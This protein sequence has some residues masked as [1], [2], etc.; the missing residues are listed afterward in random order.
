MKTIAF[1]AL[2]YRHL[3]EVWRDRDSAR[4]DEAGAF[5]PGDLQQLLSVYG[6]LLD[7]LYRTARQRYYDSFP[8]LDDNLPDG[9][10][11]LRGCQPWV[12]PYISQLL[13]VAPLSPLEGGRRAEVANAIGWRQRKGT[14]DVAE[15]IA[16]EVAALE[17]EIHEGWRRVA[18]TARPGLPLLPAAS[19]GEAELVIAGSAADARAW[20]APARARHPGLPNGTPDLRSHSRAV[21]SDG[22]DPTVQ[23]T[24]YPHVELSGLSPAAAAAE[25]ERVRKEGLL[26][27]QANRHGVPCF[28]GSYQDVSVRTVDLRTPDWRRGH[29][30]P[31]RI[32]LHLPPF[33]GLCPG[34]AT[35]KA[36]SA[37]AT[38]A[39]AS[40]PLPATLPLQLESADGVVTLRA[41]P[42]S[43][44]VW[45]RGPVVLAGAGNWRF[46]DLDFDTRP[47]APAG[48]VALQD[49]QVQ[50]EDGF[51]F[52]GS[53][54]QA[55]WPT[56]LAAPVHALAALP[57]GHPVALQVAGDTIT[58]RR[59][60]SEVPTRLT[61][62]VNLAL[63]RDWSFEDLWLDGE[64]KI[65][66][67]QVSLERCALKRVHSHIIDAAHPVVVARS[68]LFNELLAPRGR[69]ELEY[70]TVLDRC[71][72]E[73][74]WASDCIFMAFP[75]KDLPVADTDVPE[76]GC[77][78]YAR[79]PDLPGLPLW[80]ADGV[81]SDLRVALGSCT[82]AAPVFVS[83]TFGKPG[84]GV[85]HPASALALRHGAED[86]GELG[87]YH[88]EKHTLREQAV[89]DKLADYL[90]LGITPVLAP[91][92]TLLCAPP[93][94][95]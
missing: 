67:G 62:T 88:E 85:L 41:L 89:L 35:G 65:S 55:Q 56:D 31:K 27:R 66:A 17:A 78:R 6:E 60:D 18:V 50:D 12:L 43:R 5:L 91:D 79:L 23:R 10:G 7:A 59:R 80:M 90:P 75:R 94:A 47:L 33:E 2:Q 70:C 48:H 87:A 57:T 29:A 13:D 11:R 83:D 53:T 15:R 20:L 40:L 82:S 26:W 95:A 71:V 45:V 28:P 14:L 69:V 64:L 77:L 37:I 34:N 58:V 52:E 81:V 1:A 4:T 25:R 30:H 68:C 51:G 92:D 74:L 61:G 16:E 38:V 73:A 32:V 49:C 44:R 19:F 8:D 63:A 76:A 22:T 39:D 36:W 9:E 84:C 86:G 21:R 3:P 46:I 24:R 93:A 72:A 54:T 42:P